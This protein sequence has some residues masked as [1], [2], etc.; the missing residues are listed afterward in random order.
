MQLAGALELLGDFFSG[1]SEVEKEFKNQQGVLGRNL[2]CA[3]AA[4]L[5]CT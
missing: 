2:E 3:P 4:C 1:Q 5:L